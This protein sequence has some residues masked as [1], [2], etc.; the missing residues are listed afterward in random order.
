MITTTV[1]EVP[2]FDLFDASYRDD[3]AAVFRRLREEPPVF[4]TK[5]GFWLLT[6]YDDCAQLMR[7][8]RLSYEYKD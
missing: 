5:Y 6:R 4:R 8:P 3:P 7:D 1:P 2:W